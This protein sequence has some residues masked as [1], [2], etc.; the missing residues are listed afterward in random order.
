MRSVLDPVGLLRRAARSTLVLGASL[1][2][3]VAG[4]LLFL[5]VVD[6]NAYVA[7]SPR[8][9]WEH[10]AVA[11]NRAALWPLLGRTLADAGLGFVSGLSLA[12][13][14]ATLFAFSRPLE[15]MFLPTLTTLRAI[16]MVTVAPII[17]LALG[18]GTAGTAFIGAAIVFVPA[19]LTMLQGLRSASRTDLD[20]CRAFGGSS[21]TAYVKVIL[22]HAVPT[23]FAAAR[24]TVTTSIVGALLAEW[25]ATGAGLGGQMM[26]D[27]NEFRFANL[28]AS[29][30]VLTAVCVALYQLIA[31]VESAVRSRMSGR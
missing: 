11:E 6:V 14:V 18:R 16:P 24:I 3:L 5:A 9:V 29:V 8:D 22:P 21:W 17:V 31:L 10:L 12:A 26:R 28:W 23:W 15:Q 13:A 2:A 25:L 7:K 4:W 20:V 19:L 30:V 27:A 1:A